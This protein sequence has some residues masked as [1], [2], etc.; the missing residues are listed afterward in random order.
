MLLED[1]DFALPAQLIAQ[2]PLDKR[3]SSRLLQVQGDKYVHGQFMDIEAL[4]LPNDL[5]ILNNT[6]VVKARV[7]GSKTT[8]GAAEIL[9][10]RVLDETL[11]L[12]QV[13]VSKALKEGA[14][15]RVHGAEIEVIERQGVF[16]KLKFPG[17]VFEF[18][19]QHGEVPLPPYIDRPAADDDQQRYQTVF[20][21]IPGAVAAPT[22]GLHFDDVL[23]TE[24]ARLKISK[25]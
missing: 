22:A 3:T 13:K 17:N 4:L 18:L 16:Y 23:E 7:F 25:Q 14:L 11:A 10:E 1:F 9:L 12:C 15:L 6:K 5:L 8:G 20:S 2:S 19:Q 24:L 21:K